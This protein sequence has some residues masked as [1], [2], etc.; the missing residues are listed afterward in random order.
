MPNPSTLP[1]DVS[2]WAYAGLVA[3]NGHLTAD[4]ARLN[5]TLEQLSQ[6][7]NTKSDAHTEAV[8]KNKL[9]EKKLE[10]EH[11]KG[12]KLLEDERAKGTKL[13][14]KWEA[15]K[16]GLQKQ[17]GE[18]QS[19]LDNLSNRIRNVK[20]AFDAYQ[21]LEKS[22]LD[23]LRSAHKEHTDRLEEH[24]KSELIRMTANVTQF[25]AGQRDDAIA[26]VSATFAGA[27]A[28][29][30][31]GNSGIGGGSGGAI[32][33]GVPGGSRPAGDPRGPAEENRSANEKGKQ[34]EKQN[35]GREMDVDEQNDIDPSFGDD[36]TAPARLVQVSHLSFLPIPCWVVSILPADTIVSAFVPIRFAFNSP[37]LR[38]RPP[39]SPLFPYQTRNHSDKIN[40]R[41]HS[42]IEW[43][44]RAHAP[45]MLALRD[46]P[47]QQRTSTVEMTAAP[48]RAPTTMMA[49]QL[50]LPGRIYI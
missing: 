45:R 41:G 8:K 23:E 11:A 30:G 16:R 35:D 1:V 14:E 4:N 32:A 36:Q 15:E 44:H 22:K 7:L 34:R 24:F 39:T 37:I 13:Q 5:A 42:V 3:E 20:G 50:L 9:L 12:V 49:P 21:G 19:Q 46:Q 43:F 18:K 38:G 28:A 2:Q 33:A 26:R 25:L 6:E 17:L 31:L 48:M 27:D 47:L 10:N 40:S 29:G